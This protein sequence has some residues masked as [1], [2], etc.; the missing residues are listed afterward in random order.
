MSEEDKSVLG[1][2]LPNTR[3]VWRK[4]EIENRT[5]SIYLAI[6]VRAGVVNVFVVAVELDVPR[7]RQKAP[8]KEAGDA[9]FRVL[10][11]VRELNRS[12]RSWVVRANRHAPLCGDAIAISPVEKAVRPV[13]IRSV[14]IRDERSAGKG[15]MKHDDGLEALHGGLH[16]RRQVAIAGGEDYWHALHVVE[17]EKGDFLELLEG[18]EVKLQ[19]RPHL[20]V[21]QVGF[22]HVAL[23]LEDEPDIRTEAKVRIDLGEKSRDR[24]LC[25]ESRRGKHKKR[26][27][28]TVFPAFHLGC[29]SLFGRFGCQGFNDCDIRNQILWQTMPLL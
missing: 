27:D 24:C 16:G 7:D 21:V 4:I 11:L 14:S 25:A 3:L 1:A 20:S 2:T 10:A 12:V 6:R 8:C 9:P 5:D 22:L 19:A 29:W 28:Q 18:A 15:N 23:G 17:I 13:E 26:S